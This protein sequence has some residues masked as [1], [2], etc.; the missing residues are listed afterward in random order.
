MRLR[1]CIFWNSYS[2]E[3]A[4]NYAMLVGTSEAALQYALGGIEKLGGMSAEQLLTKVAGIDNAILRVAAAAGI[5]LGS[6]VAEEELQ[7]FLEPLYRTLVFG[8]DYSAPALEEILYTALLTVTTTIIV[9]GGN[10]ASYSDNDIKALVEQ[11]KEQIKEDGEKDLQSGEM[12]DDAHLEIMELN[13]PKARGMMAIYQMGNME[14]NV[15]SG[16]VPDQQTNNVAQYG[17]EFGKMGTY[18]ESPNVKVDWNQ[19]AEHGTERMRQRNMTSEMIDDIVENGK[20]LSQNNGNK[21]VFITRAGVAV[22][23]KEGRL[24][25]AWSSAEFDSTMQEIINKLFGEVQ[26]YE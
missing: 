17:D 14:E 25:T 9:E 1:E 3:Q 19:Y 12:P 16:F 15:E 22:V 24:I 8:E 26:E 23:S 5:K 21:F 4:E 11:S 7:L 6:E 2:Q 10:I 18:V 13:P 20:V